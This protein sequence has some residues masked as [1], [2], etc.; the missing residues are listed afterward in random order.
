MADGLTH[1]NAKSKQDLTMRQHP[2]VRRRH[3]C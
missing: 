2:V 3:R 1:D